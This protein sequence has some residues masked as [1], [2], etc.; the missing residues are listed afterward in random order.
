MSQVK[1]E[2]IYTPQPNEILVVRGQID[3]RTVQW[4]FNVEMARFRPSGPDQ[5]FMLNLTGRIVGADFNADL[6]DRIAT[7]K[8]SINRLMDHLRHHCPDLRADL[9]SLLSKCDYVAS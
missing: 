9:G 2:A 5:T 6:D 7:Q 1:R 3:S 8:A 4:A